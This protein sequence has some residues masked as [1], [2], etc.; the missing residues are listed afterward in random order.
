[1][2]ILLTFLLFS[3]SVLAAPPT[4]DDVRNE[5]LKHQKQLNI[6]HQKERL[7]EGGKG[8]TE[9]RVNVQFTLVKD[10]GAVKKIAIKDAPTADLRSCLIGVFRGL[11]FTGYDFPEEIKVNQP[12]ILYLKN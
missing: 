11:T 9:M 4:P 8:G 6:C 7:S 1:M 10:S 12:V 5:I 3:T 2:K